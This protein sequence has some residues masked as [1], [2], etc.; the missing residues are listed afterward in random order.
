MMD[1]I[2]T[3]FVRRQSITNL[4][5]PSRPQLRRRAL[6]EN[7]QTRDEDEGIWKRLLENPKFSSDVASD[8]GGADIL[9]I[10]S[11][12]S[13]SL[14]SSSFDV[15]ASLP[16]S[17][18]LPFSSR[19]SSSKS[20]Q[21][22]SITLPSSSEVVGSTSGFIST[23]EPSSAAL[24]TA[25]STTPSTPSSTFSTSATLEA[26]SISSIVGSTSPSPLPT[27]TS[28]ATSS[29]VGSLSSATPTPTTSVPSASPTSDPLSAASV[30]QYFSSSFEAIPSRGSLSASG[31]S[32]GVLSS[33]G[34]SASSVPTSSTSASAFSA[35]GSQ[36]PSSL[37][38]SSLA[39]GIT[40]LP[41]QSE[42]SSA[43]SF[44]AALSAS[45]ASIIAIESSVSA[46]SSYRLF[47]TPSAQ[48]KLIA[49]S[50]D[51]PTPVAT[52]ISRPTTATASTSSSGGSAGHG[53][54]AN[55][56]FGTIGN[57]QV[58][59]ALTAIVVLIVVAVFFGITAC[60]WGCCRR[61][62]KQKRALQFLVDE[63]DEPPMS[64]WIEPN[65]GNGDSDPF[66]DEPESDV[67]VRPSPSWSRRQ[68]PVSPTQQT[69][70]DHGRSRIGLAVT[71]DYWIDPLAAGTSRNWM[72]G[73]RS[74]SEEMEEEGVRRVNDWARNSIRGQDSWTPQEQPLETSFMLQ[75]QEDTPSSY[76]Q[77]SVLDTQRNE[78][79]STD[80]S[81][82]Y[83][84]SRSAP[85]IPRSRFIPGPS[86][87]ASAPLINF[88]SVTTP[89]TIPT[90]QESW[91]VALDRV[92]GSAAHYVSG[93]LHPEQ[94]AG[95]DRFTSFASRRV[96]I[97]S[98]VVMASPTPP[99]VN[100]PSPYTPSS[101]PRFAFTVPTP[102]TSVY[103]SPRSLS[104]TADEDPQLAHRRPSTTY[105]PPTPILPSA[106]EGLLVD[107]ASPSKDFLRAPSFSASI[108]RPSVGSSVWAS[109][110]DFSGGE[111]GP[112]S[113]HR[114]PSTSAS[115]DVSYASW[116]MTTPTTK[117]S[118]APSRPPRPQRRPL[119]IPPSRP[120]YVSHVPL[121][122]RQQPLS[123]QQRFSSAS[124]PFA[125][126]PTPRPGQ[127][128]TTAYEDSYF[129]REQDSYYSNRNSATITSDSNTPLIGSG[130]SPSRIINVH[131][132]LLG[133]RARATLP[134]AAATKSKLTPNS[135]LEANLATV[136]D[137]IV[138]AH[139]LLSK[140]PR[141]PT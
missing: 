81:P 69:L 75:V 109:A 53:T 138:P 39:S 133:S 54:T 71:S 30:S 95:E 101:S 14:S 13:S 141:K 2:V 46:E 127:W 102:S 38:S 89:P 33:S 103:P 9:T 77:K 60:L 139:L 87:I 26:S 99:N 131:Q 63:V 18:S 123:P 117:V 47:G 55:D 107:L 29:A 42:L 132:A 64:N 7:L 74:P 51:S 96:V 40:A 128:P 10:S 8:Q 36:F 79:Y 28:S 93:K 122:P 80:D 112:S 76:S 48:T 78:T 85:A 92:M 61:K 88:R 23:T 19:L 32:T 16:P 20:S 116:M 91:R 124:P 35:S 17:S 135:A 94:T 137:D 113:Q 140:I 44:A 67:D 100:A 125:T 3:S 37:S 45:V 110:E 104:T 83:T 57:P 121:S 97:S 73:C 70:S 86:Q 62:R 27:A 90:P 134:L 24:S 136:D 65:P 108:R 82:L 25:S 58:R 6:E 84:P 50:N 22:I 34:E 98:P 21:T 56:L 115:S 43:A 106:R 105:S 68:R 15:S 11:S 126:P 114:R 130:G 12:S 119:P 120:A 41:L 118:P 111:G 31:E 4:S 49:P 59:V 52:T 66:L 72:S 1:S 129:A 5:P